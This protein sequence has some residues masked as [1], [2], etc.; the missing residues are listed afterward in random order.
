MNLSPAEIQSL[1]A[2]LAAWIPRVGK[3]TRG[4]P[5]GYIG[6]PVWAYEDEVVSIEKSRRSPMMEIE[7]RANGNPAVMIDNEG[8]CIR[9]HGETR[10]ILAH[11]AKLVEG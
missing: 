11:L 3:E 1:F 5:L 10:T 2:R 9:M 4:R 7:I 8:R 6:E